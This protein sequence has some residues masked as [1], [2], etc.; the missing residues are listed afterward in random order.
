LIEKKHKCSNFQYNGQLN[1]GEDHRRIFSEAKGFLMPTRLPEAL[2]RTIIESFSKGTPV[3]GSYNG[4]L[5]ELIKDRVNGLKFDLNNLDVDLDFK[6]NY[7]EIFEN[8]KIFHINNE[9]D[10]LIEETKSIK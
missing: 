3:I 2:G 5:D 6:F 1:K 8:S 10:R 7:R 4:S 9:I